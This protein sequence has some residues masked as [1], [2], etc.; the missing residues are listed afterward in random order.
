V[1]TRQLRR[2]SEKTL[3]AIRC[4]DERWTGLLVPRGLFAG[5]RGMAN[6][7]HP[8]P[9]IGAEPRAH[10][11]LAGSGVRQSQPRTLTA[12]RIWDICSGLNSPSGQ[13]FP[14]VNRTSM[15]ATVSS[16]RFNEL[17]IVMRRTRPN[18]PRNL[19]DSCNN[20]LMSSRNSSE[21]GF[22]LQEKASVLC[23]PKSTSH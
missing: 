13:G 22:I 23:A 21:R 19:S 3:I 8:I 5:E 16:P 6:F 18:S 4:Q 7:L 10:S 12:G 9:H 2:A 17:N 1:S 11:L 14:R 15:F 20:S